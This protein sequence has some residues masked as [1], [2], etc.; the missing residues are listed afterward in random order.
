M[1]FEIDQDAAKQWR[2]RL[3]AADHRIL[4]D[5]AEGYKNKVDCIDEIRL[6]KRSVGPADVWDASVSPAIFIAT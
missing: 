1:Y 6:I 2:W 3:R 4:A 5:S